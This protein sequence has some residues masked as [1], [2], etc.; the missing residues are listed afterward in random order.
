MQAEADSLKTEAIAVLSRAFGRGIVD[1][2]DEMKA[3]LNARQVAV[4]N[5]Y[6]QM[7]NPKIGQQFWRAKALAKAARALDGTQVDCDATFQKLLDP[8]Q[9]RAL[10]LIVSPLARK[11]PPITWHNNSK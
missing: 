10:L 8:D 11:M 4:A 9:Y 1:C 2:S 3:L 5:Q 6:P 7:C